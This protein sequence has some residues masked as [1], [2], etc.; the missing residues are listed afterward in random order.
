MGAM[1]TP[2]NDSQLS[3][4]NDMLATSIRILA[5]NASFETTPKQAARIGS[6]A[7]IL[8]EA[9]R[10]FIA[11]IP[12]ETAENMIATARRLRKEGMVPVPHLPARNMTSA[13]MFE[14]MV[15][16]L[17]NAGI[18]H[19]LVIAGGLPAPSGPY[20]SSLQLLERGLFE[21]S[22]YATLYVAGHP[23]GSPDIPADE[24]RTA[25]A[26]KNA[27]ASRTGMD[28]RIATQFTFDASIVMAWHDRTWNDGNRLPMR[29][30]LAGPASITSLMKYAS[31]CGV[32]ASSSFLSKAGSRAL[33]LVGT[34]AP[35]D[36]MTA[37]ARQR[38]ELPSTLIEGVH[39]YPFGGFEKTAHWVGAVRR[40]EF[41]LSRDSRG[42]TVRG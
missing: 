30:G 4:N 40:G 31:M 42:F 14:R 39:I 20:H 35:D 21:R 11:F 10:V 36:V 27:F 37:L 15:G 23:E 17:A 18:D 34:R 32:K 25:L 19:A 24:V 13:A 28:V 6:F 8:P 2:A 29:I 38:L 33:K 16:D 22:G 5:G 12:G 1:V 3:I 26:A 41:S 7:E 9:T